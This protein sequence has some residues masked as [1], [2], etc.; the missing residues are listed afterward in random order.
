MLYS[1]LHGDVCWLTASLHSHVPRGCSLQ[2]STHSLDTTLL[3][4]DTPL[5]IP[6]TI[7]N[8]GGFIT[9]SLVEYHSH[10]GRNVFLK[11]MHFFGSMYGTRSLHF[12]HAQKEQFSWFRDAM[13]LCTF[14]QM[15]RV[16]VL[17]LNLSSAC[18]NPGGRES[19]NGICVGVMRGNFPE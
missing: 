8:R 14:H 11:Q 19:S 15:I 5:Y 18:A 4:S 6:C 7:P 1:F 10:Q 13:W 2:L 16:W 3:A 12:L 9:L 17:D